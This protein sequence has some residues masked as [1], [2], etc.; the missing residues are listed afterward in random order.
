MTNAH[1]DGAA[2]WLKMATRQMGNTCNTAARNNEAIFTA[3]SI[4]RN[5]IP[6]R[7]FS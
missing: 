3:P 1:A 5:R 6:S 4:Y 7:K 2:G